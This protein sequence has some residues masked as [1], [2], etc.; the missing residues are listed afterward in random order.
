M[1][2]PVEDNMLFTRKPYQIDS[3][4]SEDNTLNIGC[5][6]KEYSEA[7]TGGRASFTDSKGRVTISLSSPVANIIT[8]KISNH[9]TEPRA[10]STEVIEL[11][12]SITGTTEDRGDAIVFKSGSLEAVINKNP[13]SIKYFYYGTEIARQSEKM[14]VFYKTDAGS[15]DGYTISSNVYTGASFDLRPGEIIY[16]L[17]GA[18]SSVIRNGQSVKCDDRSPVPGTEHIPF[19]VSSSKYGL[20]VNTNRPVTFDVGSED[21]YVR[22]EAEGEEAEYVIIA[23]DSM[24]QILET[25]NQLN[26]RAPALPYTTGGISLALDD[27]FTLTSQGIIDAL[28]NAISSGVNVKELWLGNSW[29]PAYAPYGFTWDLSRFPDPKTFARSVSDLGV[30]LGI[31]INPFVS[32]RAPEFADLLDTGCFVSFPDGKAVICDSEMGGVSL[33]DLNKPDARSFVVNAC[34]SLSTDGFNVYESDY[35]GTLAEA[36][37]KAAQKEGLLSGFIGIMNS[38]LCDI[39]ARERGRLGSFIIAESVCSGDQRSPFRNIFTAVSPD[40]TDL[41][42]AV[43]NTISYNITGFGGINIDIP[44]KELIDPKLFERWA[45]FASYVPHAR[46]RGTL[47]FLEDAKTLDCIK[48]FCAIRTGLAPYIYSSLCE[49]INFGTPVIRAMG[50]E[51]AG[52]PASVFADSEYMLGSSL[53]VAPVATSGDSLRIYIPSGIWTDFMTH[54]K[55]QG[56]RYISRKISPNSVPVFVRPNSIVPTRTSDNHTNIGSLDNLTFTCF[57]LGNGTTAAC[58]VFGDGGQA[59]GVITAEVAG[60]KITIRTN[61]LGG[62]KR[63]I[64][65]GVFNVVG[66][67]ESVPEKL[68]YGTS[69]EFSGNE[70]VISLG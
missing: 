18:G 37:E 62:N 23:N 19:V 15:A 22:F 9:R 45:G 35:T 27:D 30:T 6:C 11:R 46:F 56:P 70:L 48:A 36:F 41:S 33:L 34:N 8:I 52:D 60:N 20:F 44:A 24:T 42:S 59:S 4:Y 54:E 63:L 26:G 17:G 50:V 40:Y 1:L 47:K 29:H 39:S 68:S 38:A 53:L 2:A 21:S 28:R 16:G 14:P 65:S 3:V 57:G 5:M 49:N 64:L 7:L 51:F 58:E 32:E 66:L 31:S 13:F 25:Y 10:K 67:S 69:I 12:P 43:K 55:I 61:N